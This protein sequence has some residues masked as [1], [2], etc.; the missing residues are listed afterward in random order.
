MAR[1]ILLPSFTEPLTKARYLGD[2]EAIVVSL[3]WGSLIGLN[4]PRPGQTG[5]VAPETVIEAQQALAERSR[6]LV[7]FL[8]SGGVLVV[9]VEAASLMWGQGSY[10][11]PTVEVDS[12][13]WI[14]SQVYP[15]L[16]SSF[17]DNGRSA[18]QTGRGHE[19]DFQ[20]L[21]HPL[22]A[23]IHGAREYKGRIHK[24][25]FE[26]ADATVLATTRIGDPVAGEILFGP[27]LVFLVPSGVDNKELVAAVEKIL[28]TRERQRDTWHLRE[29]AVLI[30]EEAAIRAET[31]DRVASLLKRRQELADLRVAVM[32][33]N[34]N[35]ARAI[36]YYENGTSSR[37]ID[38]AMH[39]LYKLVELLE[40]YFGGSEEKLAAALNVPKALFKDGIKRLAN[41]PPLNF[42]HAKS[43]KTEGADVAK[44][45]QARDAAHTLVQLFIEYC[46][47]EE[48]EKRAAQAKAGSSSR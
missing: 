43:G 46:C 3:D 19:I 4:G 25:V 24:D 35:L 27:G 6:E 23:V 13:S 37:P 28:A 44:V 11:S 9:K 33:D 36:K 2:Y 31:R 5:Q 16:F 12:L 22:E 30:E 34:V 20:E 26:V 21:D 17:G 42:R 14:S 38:S 15:L 18:F 29:E 10:P 8:E 39:D 47:A 32:R 7:R 45:D 48:L 1:R 41:Q 40:D